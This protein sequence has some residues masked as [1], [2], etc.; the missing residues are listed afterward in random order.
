MSVV[1]AEIFIMGPPETRMTVDG[2]NEGRHS[3]DPAG[4][5]P[6]HPH[7]NQLPHLLPQGLLGL[8]QPGG[9]P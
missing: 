7:G 5:G 2:Y 6:P 8:L 1:L 3:D 4:A 9:G